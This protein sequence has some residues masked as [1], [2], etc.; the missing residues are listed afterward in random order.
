VLLTPLQVS[1]VTT[2]AIIYGFGADPGSLT[3]LIGGSVAPLASESVGVTLA[4]NLLK[5]FPGAG[6]VLGGVIEGTVAST[7]TA[8]I[9]YGFQRAFHQ[10]ALRQATG[11]ENMSIEGVGQFLKQAL[12][13]LMEEIRKRG[14]KNVLPDGSD[15]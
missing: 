6:S 4:G 10:L 7:I 15:A 12:P 5:F 3:A 2:I 9:G 8:A 11:K 13:A 1:M 14:V